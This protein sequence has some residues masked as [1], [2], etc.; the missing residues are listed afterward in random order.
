MYVIVAVYFA[1]FENFIVYRNTRRLYLQRLM[2]RSG[3][4]SS[5]IMLGLDGRVGA[6]PT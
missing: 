5:F 6:I 4:V 3:V 2:Q 1:Y